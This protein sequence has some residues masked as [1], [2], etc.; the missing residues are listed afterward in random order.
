[1]KTEAGG[2][3]A[4]ANDAV[5]VHPNSV[6]LRMAYSLF[7]LEDL[8]VHRV[9]DLGRSTVARTHSYTQLEIWKE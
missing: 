2:D 3:L 9:V 7:W 6:G 1:M 5:N 8:V 4:V